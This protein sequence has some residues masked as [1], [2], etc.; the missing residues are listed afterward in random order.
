MSIS[1]CEISW[2]VECQL[3]SK[4]EVPAPPE[5]CVPPE[6]CWSGAHSHAG[7]VCSWLDR[8][9][10]LCFNNLYGA[11]N[12]RSLGSAASPYL[13][14]KQLIS[15]ALKTRDFAPLYTKLLKTSVLTSPYPVPGVCQEQTH[16]Q[17]SHIDTSLPSVTAS[18]SSIKAAE[19]PKSGIRRAVPGSVA[20]P[21]ASV[22]S[23]VT[24]ARGRFP[25]PSMERQ[26]TPSLP[27]SESPA[28][29][30][31]GQ[32]TVCSFTLFCASLSIF[33]CV[34]LSPG[35]CSELQAHMG[36]WLHSGFP[37]L[38]FDAENY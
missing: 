28:A 17:G 31:L 32:S 15:G 21:L 1:S 4:G 6:W 24:P 2:L 13:L 23:S 22:S 20:Q 36:T 8:V 33:P 5:L 7:W 9:R 30:E 35:M 27:G 14:C 3:Q 38:L 34:P 10:W 29:G 19:N 12:L 26:L 37:P 16:L 11:A 25:R 18:V